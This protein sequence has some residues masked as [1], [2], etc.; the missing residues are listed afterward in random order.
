MFALNKMKGLMII[1]KKRNLTEI[2]KIYVCKT[3]KDNPEVIEKVLIQYTDG[4]SSY[5]RLP[6]FYNK[7]N[8]DNQVKERDLLEKKLKLHM[9]KLSNQN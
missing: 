2:E 8:S 7:I 1:M 5:F 9:K 3:M 4:N 6:S